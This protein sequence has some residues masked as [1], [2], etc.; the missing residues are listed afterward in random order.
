M[1]PI[2]GGGSH[3]GKSGQKRKNGESKVFHMQNNR[4]WILMATNHDVGQKSRICSS[5]PPSSS[6]RSQDVKISL[7]HVRCSVRGQGEGRVK[8][9]LMRNN[10][11]RAYYVLAQANFFS[12]QIELI[13]VLVS[14]PRSCFRYFSVELHK[15]QT[16]IQAPDHGSYS[17]LL[18]WTS[19]VEVQFL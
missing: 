15:P 19:K 2:F 12:D 4:V 1:I 13:R 3:G 5:P 18:C 17:L 11:E 16:E 14:D 9:N 7:V 8:F 6:S 10:I